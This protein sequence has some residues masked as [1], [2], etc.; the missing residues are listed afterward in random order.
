MTFDQK[1]IAGILVLTVALFIWGK[2]RHDIVAALSL[3]SCILAGLVPSDMAFVGFGHPAVI[4]VAAVLVISEV[5]RR[6]GVVDLISQSLMPYTNNLLTHILLLTAVVTVASSFMN[7]V[8]A[9]ALMLPVAI[10]TCAKHNRSP[11]IIL[12]P[13]AFG[14][15]LGG[16]TTAIGTPPNIIIA[17]MRAEVTGEPFN[18][19]D[20]SPVG[21][22]IA[23]L[24]VLFIGLIGWRFIPKARLKRSAP[25]HL[26]AIDDYL[27]EVIIT[28][29]SELVGQR[30]DAIKGLGEGNIE[31]VGI[32]HRHGETMSMKRYQLLQAGDIL[33]LQGDPSEIHSLLDNNDLELI[34]SADKKFEELTQGNLTLVEGV[35]KRGSCLEGRD[36]PFLRRRSNSSIALVGLAREGKRV[37]RR[38]RRQKFRAG[39]ILLL[40]GAADS[41]EEQ[42][43]ELGLV[44]LAERNL[45]IGTNRRVAM[46]LTIF[47]GAVALGVLKI[48]PLAIV[49][50][51]AV[52]VYVLLEL[53]PVRNLYDAIDWPVIILLASLIPVGRALEQT[54][55]T[56]LAATQLLSATSHLPIYMVMGMLLIMTMWLSDV[57]NNAATAVVMAPLAYSI[58]QGLN[59]N[60]DAFFMTVAIGAS[61]A[62]MTPIGHQSNTLVM[63]P[64]GY[65][66]SD[67]W[68]MGLPLD[69]IIVFASIPLILLVWPL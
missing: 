61:C 1:L 16:M 33:I 65:Q 47:A 32:A 37:Q 64:G 31:V 56:E 51:M 58:A 24:G 62:F 19:F 5:M 9:L 18:M 69:V 35:I 21:V 44:P 67:Y 49:F 55:L 22:A 30:P 17:M 13:L 66:F 10:T 36:V 20:F 4:T 27:T 54:G 42:L 23:I 68:R 6:C 8:G 45:L 57:I 29:Q 2:Y 59:V 38:I 50:V 63:G 14:S 28:E 7:N 41:V 12:M 11:A 15:I 34:T 52:L 40:Q 3:G 39:D 25:E 60:P 46:A 43:A 53:I 26:F 48:L